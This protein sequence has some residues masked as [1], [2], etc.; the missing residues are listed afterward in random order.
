MSSEEPPIKKQKLEL[1]DPDEPLTQHDVISFQKE[2]LFRC[3]N[4]KRVELEA[5]TKQY[6][7]VHDKWEQNVH[8][9]AT[10]MSV[11][12]TAASHLRGLCNEELEK[13]LCDEMINAGESV[14]KERTDEFLNLSRKYTNNNGS[15]DSKI[16]SLGLELQRANKTKSELRLQNKKLTDEIDSL[17]AYYH[18]LVRS[19]DREDS[20]TVK[21]VFNKQK[22]DD[23]TDNISNTEQR[24]TSVSPVLTNG[25]THAKN[26]V[27]TEQEA[28]NNHTDSSQSSGII[29]EEK[30]KLF[31]QYENK[32]T[33]LESHNSSLN[34]IIEELENYKQLNEKELAQTRLEISN[35]LSEKHSNEEERE[36][37]LH[38]IEKLKASNTDLTLTN[39]S[40]LSKFQ[41]LAKEK[42]TFQ[43]KI[44]SDFEKTLESL[45]AQNLALEKDLV[46]VRTT[47]DELISKVAILEAETSKSVLIS[48]LKQA[49]DILRDQW[50]KIEFRN[51][52]S[53][54]SDALLKEIQDLESAFKELSSLTHKKYSEYLNHESVISKL[55]I[56]K[57]KAD[58]KYFASMRSKDSI[59]V[60]NKNLSK[61][62]NKANE[63]ILQLKD[64]DKLYKQKIESLHKQLALSQNNEKRLVDS[65]KAANLKVMN[66]NSEIQKQKKLL[67]F[68]S[69]Q[70][71]ELINELTEA[72]GMLKSKELEIEF[73]ENELQTALKKNEKLEEFLSKENYNM[74]KPSSLAT[75]NLDEDSMA[76]ELENF[77][78][79]VYCSLCSKNWKNMAIRTCGHVFCEDCC[80]ERLAARMRKC[81]TCNKPFSSNDLLMV[82]L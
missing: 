54:S 31:L 50:E 24:P 21:R 27:K 40:F 74:N 45:K 26:E 25:A 60:E 61:S 11:L 39:E 2:A 79:L 76:E 64:T 73:K 17:K 20:M 3:L 43:E 59:L 42:D 70:K 6:S 5:L 37:L 53:P 35:L 29:E 80:K 12:S 4:S 22:T 38:Q 65:N 77:R 66:L 1:S 36:D 10:L 9:L 28:L 8:T 68:T 58:Q 51:N 23:N 52:Q 48:D 44:S 32:I 15:S 46:R 82:H 19:Y 72:N 34:R 55:T 81:P 56:E 14:D 67:D 57:T 63:L 62:L 71:N 7:T 16:D 69:S 78:T 47:R 41:E 13:T 30:K 49:L 75:T 33:D 18:G